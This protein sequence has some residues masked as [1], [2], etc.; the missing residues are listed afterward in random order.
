MTRWNELTKLAA[1]APRRPLHREAG[2]H[3]AF[4][5]ALVHL[6]PESFQLLAALG[7]SMSAIRTAS[8]IWALGIPT[9]TFELNC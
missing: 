9:V 5:R 1:D 6:E 3:I 8:P 7:R 2:K 4:A